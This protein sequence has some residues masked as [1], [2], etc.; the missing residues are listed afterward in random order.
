MQQMSGTNDSFVAEYPSQ[1]PTSH[2]HR[3]RK[4]AYQYRARIELRDG[5]GAFP[6]V[7]KLAIDFVADDKCA[8]AALLDSLHHSIHLLARQRATCW[9]R[10]TRA[11]YYF[12][13]RAD[14]SFEIIQ[15]KTEI[16]GGGQL[17]E[18][19][20]SSRHAG[21]RRIRD[22][23]GIRNQHFI[24]RFDQRHQGKIHR[25]LRAGGDDYLIG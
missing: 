13:L 2:A 11:N 8:R 23:A 25:F 21:N 18:C 4:A 17:I 20:A 7:I 3:L 22:K 5:T 24:A 15:I 1:A 14:L 9:V 16:S 12:R 6:G 10:W 19:W